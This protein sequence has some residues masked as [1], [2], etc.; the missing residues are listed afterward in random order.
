MKV[1]KNCGL[2]PLLEA[3]MLKKRKPL[4][5][6]KHIQDHSRNFNEPGRL[7]ETGSLELV[8]VSDVARAFCLKLGHDKTIKRLASASGP[9]LQRTD[10]GYIVGG[11]L[12]G[13]TITILTC[14]GSLYFSNLIVICLPTC[15]RT[16]AR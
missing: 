1:L 8:S 11:T 13:D 6:A 4:C 2:E 5:R 7:G 10:S 3:E 15:I 14:Y 12:M 16:Y 9:A